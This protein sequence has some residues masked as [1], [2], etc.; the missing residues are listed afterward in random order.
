MRDAGSPDVAPWRAAVPAHDAHKPSLSDLRSGA[1]RGRLF[2][3]RLTI[4][5]I[6]DA[7]CHHRNIW[8]LFRDERATAG[9]VPLH[10]ATGRREARSCERRRRE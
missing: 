9:A 1:A 7:L 5:S 4:R 10:Q 3:L 8:R 2:I 6:T